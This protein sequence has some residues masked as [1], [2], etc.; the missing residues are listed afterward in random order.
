MLLLSPSNNISLLFELGFPAWICKQSVFP[1]L[2]PEEDF[3]FF[4]FNCLVEKGIRGVRPAM[5][6][7]LHVVE[8]HRLPSEWIVPSKLWNLH[9]FRSSCHAGQL[10]KNSPGSHAPTGSAAFRLLRTPVPTS[11]SG[12]FCFQP[13]SHTKNPAQSQSFGRW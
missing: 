6:T 9:L 10:W 4:F 13:P 5:G 7:A 11:H 2:S 8:I 1:S 3:F 12:K